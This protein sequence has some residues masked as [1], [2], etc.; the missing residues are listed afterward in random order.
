MHDYIHSCIYILVLWEYC[1]VSLSLTL[2]SL[3]ELEE[4]SDAGKHQ[5]GKRGEK[6]RG[7]GGGRVKGKG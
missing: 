5:Q 6:I 4:G 2:N 7:R 1:T 3:P